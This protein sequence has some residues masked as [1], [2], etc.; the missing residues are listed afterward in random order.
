MLRFQASWLVESVFDNIKDINNESTWFFPCL[1]KFMPMEWLGYRNANIHINVPI[2]S[3]AVLFNSWFTN[4]EAFP[5][6]EV[7]KAFNQILMRSI[8]ININPFKSWLDV[9]F[10]KQQLDY[11]L[12]WREA[13]NELTNESIRDSFLSIVYQV[14][15]YWIANNREGVENAFPPDEIL[16]YYYKRFRAFKEH[17]A[18]FKITEQPIESLI[19]ESCSL[20]VFNLIFGDEDYLEDETLLV[21]NA[22]LNGYTDIEESKRNFTNELKHYSIELGNTKNFDFYKKICEKANTAAF[23]WSGFGISPNLYNRLLVEPMQKQLLDLYKTSKLIYKPIDS[24]SN[25]YDYILLFY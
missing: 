8:D 2:H 19:T 5:D 20:V 22:W 25:Y 4:S 23:C 16:A 3:Q 14:M 21:Y 1:W 13:A 12:Y 24:T 18:N 6:E 10:S 7:M 11:L 15:N 9:Y 17:L